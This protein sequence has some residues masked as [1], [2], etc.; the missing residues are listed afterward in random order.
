MELT[1]KHFG[2]IKDVP[3]DIKRLTV[4]IGKDGTGKSSLMRLCAA[5]QWLEKSICS[6]KVSGEWAQAHFVQAAGGI[7]AVVDRKL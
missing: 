7:P 1:A 5:F 2:Q 6:G 4:V 3:L